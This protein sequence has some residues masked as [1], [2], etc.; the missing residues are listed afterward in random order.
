MASKAGGKV[1]YATLCNQ[2]RDATAVTNVTS[3]SNWDVAWMLMQRLHS[4]DT[5]TLGDGL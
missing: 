1:N 2:S 5:E 3:H 4:D